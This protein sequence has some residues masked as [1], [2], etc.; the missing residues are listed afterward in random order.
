MLKRA[1]TVVA[2][3]CLIS[4]TLARCAVGPDDSHEPLVD[5]ADS[6]DTQT[7]QA[8]LK[9]GHSANASDRDGYT[10]LIAA[11]GYGDAT[12]VRA[13]LHHGADPNKSF[14]DFTPLMS[15]ALRS[16]DTE[17]ATMLVAAGGDPCRR[18][19]DKNIRGDT[20]L[21]IARHE[22]HLGIVDLLREP[23]SRC[24]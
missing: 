13:L 4:F 24:A 19:H 22:H 14:G 23:T 17:I 20:A 8:L 16:G 5:A 21:S 2:F 12:S 1:L 3:A 9:Q 6:G 7:V 10:A 15:V 11:A 18:Q